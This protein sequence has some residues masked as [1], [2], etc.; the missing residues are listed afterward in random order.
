ME[1]VPQTEVNN[2]GEV[3]QGVGNDMKWQEWEDNHGR[4][5][6]PI[7]NTKLMVN[8]LCRDKST[9]SGPA[10][11]FTWMYDPRDPQPKDILAYRVESRSDSIKN[12]GAFQKEDD[13]H[14]LQIYDNILFRDGEKIEVGQCVGWVRGKK[15]GEVSHY[16]IEVDINGGTRFKVPA[17]LCELQGTRW[18]DEDD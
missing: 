12:E 8:I 14:D 4:F 13:S 5:P 11:N 15:E 10:Y 9:A 7:R 1:N 3:S 6:C 17:Y 18:Q 2:F 16:V